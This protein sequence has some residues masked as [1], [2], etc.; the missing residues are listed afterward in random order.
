MSGSESDTYRSFQELQ[1]AE[2]EGEA[3][4]REY[5]DRGSR[6]LVL[7]PHGGWIEPQT[8]ELARAVAGQDLSFY[9]F[10]AMK[11]RGNERLHLTSHRFDD[12][13]ALEAARRAD[14]VLAIH[15]ERTRGEFFVMVGGGHRQLRASLE[16]ALVQAGFTLKKPREGLGGLRSD[17]ICN[18][19][20]EGGGG[21]LEISE[22]LRKQFQEQPRY[23]ERFVRAVRGVLIPL[24]MSWE[25][26]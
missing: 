6:V 24:E 20:G 4:V 26:D 8:T 11:D 16:D 13:V 19:G 23:L 17:N 3:W 15:G 18:R 9:S 7:A 22:G 21:Q 25:R 5:L 10:I 2:R 12:P 1:E 14:W